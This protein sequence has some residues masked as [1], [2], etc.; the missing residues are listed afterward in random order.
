[1]TNRWTVLALLTAART[2]M[3]FQFQAV[4]AIGPSLGAVYGVGLAEIGFAIGLYFLP[5]VVFALPGSAIGARF[6]DRPVVSFAMVLMAV[7][8]GIMALA[9]NW[10]VL[11]IG[12]AIAGVGGAL[13]NV[14]MTKMITDWFQGREIATALAIFT[15]SWPLG[16]A[17]S[18][19]ALPP[20]IGF[21]G[22]AAGFW[23]IAVQ[24]AVFEALVFGLYRAPDGGDGPVTRRKPTRA[25]TWAALCSGGVWGFFNAGL[26]IMFGFG[27]ALLVGE[28]ATL[29]RAALVTSLVVW[30]TAIVAPF[31]G[32][33]AD[34]MAR[35]D[36]LI[37]GG[38][39][40]MAVLTP[41]TALSGGH[42]LLFVL[43]GMASG[44]IAGVIMS[45]P[46]RLLPPPVRSLG[47]GMFFAVYYVAFVISPPAG[48]ALSD[49]TGSPDAAFWLGGAFQLLA[50]AG[51]W[52]YGQAARRIAAAHA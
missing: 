27:T 42:W 17:L 24:S 33:I 25:E 21:G 7:G 1:M 12:Q 31:G 10:T 38:L 29:E 22:A 45:L 48:G 36:L 13:L 2:V 18:L 3:A 47:M 52:G 30:S 16:I 46:G 5:G 9:G 8:A 43:V 51:L 49:A 26:A 11:L 37:A 34:R 39:I 14:L 35:P 44:L 4:G 6:G 32:M 28:G 23:L 40:A 50:L 19:V 41:V 15:N 20:L